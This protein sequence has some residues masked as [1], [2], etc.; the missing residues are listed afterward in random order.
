MKD[1]DAIDEIEAI[2]C[3]RKLEH[4]CLKNRRLAPSQI[5]RRNLGGQAQVNTDH[6][7]SPPSG[8]IGKAPH[9]A[10]NIENEFSRQILWTET[11]TASKRPFRPVAFVCVELSSSVH[12]PLKSET[13]RVLLRINKAR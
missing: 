10:T 5:A 13:S 7:S 11:G 3:K 1:A 2:G 6:M 4:V 9:A 8:N 12:L